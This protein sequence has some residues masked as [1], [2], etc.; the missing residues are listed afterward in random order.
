[1]L[2]TSPILLLTDFGTADPYMGQMHMVLSTLAPASRVIDISH[3]V[4]PHNLRQAGFMLAASAPYMPPDSVFLCVVDPGVGTRRSIVAVRWERGTIIAPDNGLLSLFLAQ[5]NAAQNPPLSSFVLTT[6][7]YQ[8]SATFH[9]RDI[10]CPL[11]ARLAQ[12]TPLP[13]LGTHVPLNALQYLDTPVA[14]PSPAHVHH[15]H[16][17]SSPHVITSHIQH[18]DR[19]GNCV[20]TLPVATW[21]QSLHSNPL[22]YMAPSEGTSSTKLSGTASPMQPIR[23]V[24]TY[25]ELT[26]DEVG[27]LAGSQGFLEL[28]V[29]NHSARDV[30]H[31]SVGDVLSLH[32][33]P[34]S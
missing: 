4:Q 9:G 5:Q 3:E 13:E 1:M 27:I 26:A 7:H 14:S 11:A 8:S 16:A 33:T 18:I 31:L 20:T 29:R 21:T 32:A 34:A 6:D 12:G 17:G 23:P 2:A 30:L 24:Q 22:W 10:F 15:K 19:F 25:G 28:A